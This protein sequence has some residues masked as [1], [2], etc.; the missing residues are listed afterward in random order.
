MA[1]TLKSADTASGGERLDLYLVRHGLAASRRHARSLIA[2]GQV[3]VNGVR[4]RKGRN[5][6]AA[7]VV[8][9]DRPA[10]APALRPI[11]ELPLEVLYA[12]DELVV[13]NK[14]GLLPCH[15][16]APGDR[17]T[18]MNA[19]VARYPDAALAGS[20]PLE[21][22]L[23]HRLDNGTSGAT[24]VALTEA[25]LKRLRAALKG[26]RILRRYAA[27][28]RGRLEGPLQLD[29]PIAHHPRNRRKMVAVH[30][31]RA[32]ARLKARPASSAVAPMRQIGG[33]TLVEVA[34]RTGRRHQIRIHLAEAGFPIAGDELYGGPPIAPLAPGRF[35]LHLC[36]LR[37]DRDLDH[38]RAQT[39]AVSGRGPL[40]VVAP[41]AGD[42]R[43]C[44]EALG[45]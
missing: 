23:V 17:P 44:I 41:L 26:G 29:F 43:A 5:V 22:G 45:R 28:V 14:P 40:V 25:G 32:A 10:A 9:L 11:H 18:L 19:L 39:L 31:D 37:I 12:D 36:E 7:D 1:D 27:L 13:V 4:S 33:Y 30:G 24:M 16:L 2:A 34:P 35:F 20:N 38:D 21:G 42:L 8:E 6:G 15:P 3:R